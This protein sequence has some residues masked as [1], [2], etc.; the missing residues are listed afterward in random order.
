MVNGIAVAYC[1]FMT[2][3]YLH[4]YLLRLTFRS[5]WTAH[6]TS[7]DV[8]SMRPCILP[9]CRRSFI[10]EKTNDNLFQIVRTNRKPAI[11]IKPVHDKLLLV[12]GL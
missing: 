6:E 1:R 8:K 4:F 12:V 10:E 11:A 5:K 3:E 7:I 2:T 9:D